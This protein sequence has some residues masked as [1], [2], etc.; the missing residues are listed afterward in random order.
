LK[1]T[2][3]PLIKPVPLTVSVNAALPA[4]ALAGESELRRG[5]GLLIVNAAFPDVPPPTPG[6]ETTTFTT[7]AFAMSADVTAAD[8]CVALTSVVVSAVPLKLT[9]DAAAKFVPFTVRVNPGPPAVVFEGDSEAIVGAP[10]R[11]VNENAASVA[12]P[13]ALA[14]T[15]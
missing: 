14:F 1:L 7:P 4:L 5:R 11:L 12:S 3:A 2:V 6:V 8:S 10:G 9:T 13:F 15:V